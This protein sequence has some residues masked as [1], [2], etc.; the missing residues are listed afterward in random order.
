MPLFVYRGPVT[1]YGRCIDNYWEGETYA[2]SAEKART[3]LEY[4]YKKQN[5]LAPNAPVKLP[6]LIF[7]EETDN[8]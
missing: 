3:N 1:R 7:K 4:R 8:E 5:G 6:G 2:P